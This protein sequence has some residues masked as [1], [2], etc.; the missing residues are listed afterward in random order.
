[1]DPVVGDQKRGLRY[2]APSSR[3]VFRMVTE[4]ALGVNRL[5]GFDIIKGP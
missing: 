5:V 4:D 1:M 3:D 2:Q